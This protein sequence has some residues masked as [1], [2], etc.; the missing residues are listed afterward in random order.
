MKAILPIAACV[1]L[2]GLQV[3]TEA[4]SQARTRYPRPLRTA[5][6]DLSTGAIVRGPASALG[7]A[8]TISDFPNLDLGGFISAETG[9]GFCEW[10]AAGVKGSV[11]NASDLMTN[12]VMAYCSSALDVCSGGPGAA[13]AITFR[14]GYTLGANGPGNP[15]N[16]NPV[17][18]LTLTGLPANT[19]HSSIFLGG[20]N[21]C[22]FLDVSFADLVPFADGPIGYSWR[23]LDLDTTGVLAAT[24]PYLSPV[25]SALGMVDA[26][27]KYCPIGVQLG[28]FSFG[29]GFTS[30]GIDIREAA[31]CTATVASY[32]SSSPPNVDALISVPAIIGQAWFAEVTHAA[33]TATFGTLLVRGSKIPGNGAPAGSFGRLLVSGAFYTDLAG[34]PDAIPPIQAD[35]L[36]FGATIP[37]ELSLACI[38]WFAQALTGG[39]GAVRLS[40]GVEGDTG[41]E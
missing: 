39:A 25:Q 9:G 4:Q 37:L 40:N 14:E 18:T 1:G 20:G 30:V 17:A 24:L 28:T 26:M 34:M 36:N 2:I 16:G 21:A 22:Y 23:F 27:D 5:T 41:T 12:F 38:D 32:N 35:Q 6:L 3:L 8:T 29:N 11:P 13:T 19:A 31:D 15:P 10:F 7:S 33:G